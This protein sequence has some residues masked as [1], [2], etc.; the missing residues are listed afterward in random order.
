VV[1]VLV[2]VRERRSG[3]RRCFGRRRGGKGKDHGRADEERV[4]ES[5]EESDPLTSELIELWLFLL[6]YY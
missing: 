6:S 5:I 1:V 3:W 2:P 4:E